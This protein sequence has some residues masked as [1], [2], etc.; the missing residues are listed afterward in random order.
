MH[1]ATAIQK[2][3]SP[4][5]YLVFTNSRPLKHF[6]KIAVFWNYTSTAG[7]EMLLIG[8]KTYCMW[9]H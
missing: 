6:D 8:I 2:K 1:R 9:I 7:V 4:G 5:S 3:T